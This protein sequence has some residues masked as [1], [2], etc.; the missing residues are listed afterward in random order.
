MNIIQKLIIDKS[1]TNQFQIIVRDETGVW[2]PSN[3]NGYGGDNGNPVNN[4]TRYIFDIFNTNTNQSYRQIQSDDLNN[5]NEY[6]NPSIARIVNKENVIIDSDNFNLNKFTDGVYKITMNVEFNTTFNGDGFVATDT[7]ANVQGAKTIFE[8]YSAIIVNDDIYKLTDRSESTLILD[9]DILGEFHSFKGILRTSETFILSDSLEDCL[10]KKMA[11]T[12][13]NCD[14][15]NI[16]NLNSM[17]ELVILNWGLQRCIEKE[18]YLQ[19]KDYLDLL[20]KLCL[21]FNC[22]C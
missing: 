11:N 20:T 12:L 15:S 2:S 9:R 1:K 10:N 19:A 16:D 14:C 18:D 6:H 13:D 22:G 7:V 3:P 5:P 21:S 4:I 17:T 8:N